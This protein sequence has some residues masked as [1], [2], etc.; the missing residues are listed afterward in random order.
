M[1]PGPESPGNIK[2]FLF[3]GLAHLPAIQKE[4]LPI[5]DG[6]HQTEFL[7]F[8]L[9]LLVLAD[10]VAM[11]KLSG[12]VGHHGRRGCR[13]LCGLLG[14]N[15]VR[16]SHYYPALPLPSY[17]KE[18]PTSS[19]PDVDVTSLPDADPEQYQKNLYEV[20]GSRNPTDY[21]RRQFKSGISKPSIF[22]GIPQIL[23]LP[24]CFAGDLMHQPVIN[25]E[26]LLFD[27]WCAG[28]DFRS[29]NRSSPWPWA[30][31]T[32]DTWNDHRRVVRKLLSSCQLHLDELLKILKRKSR[33]D[34]RPGVPLL[35][36]WRGTRCL[37]VYS[38]DYVLLPFLQ[39][40]SGHPHH[41]PT[42]DLAQTIDAGTQTPP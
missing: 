19:H 6:F 28:P 42:K 31:L 13:M 41:I 14:R 16:G 32:G 12:S 4:G 26:A 22:G 33:A 15:K 36:V 20:I 17:L 34:T 30:V 9:L 23:H 7:S 25:I 27:L 37:L 1:I 8:I 11:S 39:A 24:T 18:N 38:T 5:W 2:S 35:S 40:C 10:S 21:G 29:S 3:P